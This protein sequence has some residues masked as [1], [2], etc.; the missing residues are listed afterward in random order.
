MRGAKYSSACVARRDNID[1][2]SAVAD[3][4]GLFACEKEGFG[5]KEAQIE[6]SA[7][8]ES[9]VTRFMVQLIYDDG[10]VE[11]SERS[12]HRLTFI[13]SLCT[14]PNLW[15]TSVCFASPYS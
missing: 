4:H 12:R 11:A 2:W 14:L 6:F 13:Y 3:K 9:G 1:V 5:G 8:T 7:G 15:H 10:A